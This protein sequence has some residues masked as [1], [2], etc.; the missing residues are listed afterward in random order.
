MF[1]AEKIALVGQV[2]DVVMYVALMAGV[3]ILIVGYFAGAKKYLHKI[4]ACTI[5]VTVVGTLALRVP[6]AIHDFFSDNKSNQEQVTNKSPATT[7]AN[8][9]KKSVALSGEAFANLLL[10]LVWTGVHIGMG[11]FLYEA[12]TVTAD[13]ARPN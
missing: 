8:Q 12:M 9:P 4:F 10:Y 7:A 1:E 11:I 13:E 6:I 2:S 3:L 5:I